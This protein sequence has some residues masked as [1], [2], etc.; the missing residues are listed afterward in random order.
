MYLILTGLGRFVEEAY[1]GEIQTVIWNGLRLYQWTAISSI[2]IGIGITMIHT[3][4][5]I[6]DPGF[7]FEI[8]LSAFI[9]G[10]ITFIA[11]GV[12]FPNSNARFSRLV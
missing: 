4:I 5:I 10:F 3:E 2:L 8:L 7:N 11:M 6:L 9:G 1:R 12:D